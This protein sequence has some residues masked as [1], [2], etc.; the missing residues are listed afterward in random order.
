MMEDMRT[1]W[2]GTTP[3]GDSATLI[4]ELPPAAHGMLSIGEHLLVRGAVAAT[5]EAQVTAVDGPSVTLAV[6]GRT[7]AAV[8]HDRNHRSGLVAAN[9]ADI[10]V[11]MPSTV[12]TGVGARFRRP[13]TDTELTTV[14]AWI[15][16]DGGSAGIR[17]LWNL[18]LWAAEGRPY[19]KSAAVDVDRAAYAIPTTQARLLIEWLKASPHDLDLIGSWRWE[20]QVGYLWTG[21]GPA[22]YDER[23][24]PGGSAYP[25]ESSA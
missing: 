15:A 13:L 22:S 10:S 2:A 14:K 23:P 3:F 21:T 16:V 24:T 25:N 18:L 6:L 8:K 20:R 12:R 11:V 19:D 1:I 7:T 5:Q 4:A 17:A 9:E